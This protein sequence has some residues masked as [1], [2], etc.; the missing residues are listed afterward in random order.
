MAWCGYWDGVKWVASTAG[1]PFPVAPTP[2]VGDNDT[3]VAT[4]AFVQAATA[5]AQTNVGRNLIHNALFTVAQ[6]GAGAWTTNGAYLADRWQQWFV[7]GSI[8]TAINPASDTFRSQAGDEAMASLL[9]S[10]FTGTAGAGDVSLVQ[11]H[12]E[13]V[14]RL[15]GK[16]CHV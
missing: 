15:G 11:Q 8:S 6:R 12:I 5:T 1:N 10:T 7:G 2:P 9:Y 14:R 13:G 3:S 4:T 16:D